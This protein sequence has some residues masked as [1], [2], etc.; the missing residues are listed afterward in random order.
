[1]SARRSAFFVS[2]RTGIT[3]EM[4]G[5]S[6]LSQF[7]KVEFQRHTLPY[8][9]SPEKAVAAVARINQAFE[10]D[11][12][13]PIVFSTLVGIELRAT[14]READALVLDFFE[15]FINPLE[16]ELAQESSHTIGRSHSA[17][18]IH[19]YD[20]RIGAVN[21][22]MAHDDGV[23]AKGLSEAEVI[24]VGVSRSGKTPTSLYLALQFGIKAANYPLIPE[25]IGQMKLP[26]AIV[27][28]KSKLWGLTI[29]PERLHQIRTERRRDS[30]YAALANCRYEVQSAESLMRT[31]GIPFLDST[32]MS[33]E[34][35]STTILHQAHLV[36][37]IF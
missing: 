33:I 31:N 3:A 4:L 19:N 6:L 23:S 22:A 20:Q 34:E 30:R 1:M 21:F 24:L 27:P 26:P 29:Q 12:V 16:N 28:H 15:I 35:L 25:D 17:G 14:L 32:N 18:N 9:D 11:G 2:D 13:R 10:I 37:H 36:R 5:Q 7:D 8:V